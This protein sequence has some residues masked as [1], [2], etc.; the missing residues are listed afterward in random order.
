MG[1]S[2]DVDETETRREAWSGWKR[3]ET[4][5]GD[6]SPAIRRRVKLTVYRAAGVQREGDHGQS[7]AGLT[8][9]MEETQLRRQ[10]G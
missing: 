10:R 5:N 7:Q 1:W 3:L 2:A 9:A 6:H 8:P 4:G